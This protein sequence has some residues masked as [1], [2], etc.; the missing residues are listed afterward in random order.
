MPPAGPQLQQPEP[1]R[2]GPKP[3]PGKEIPHTRASARAHVKRHPDL[4]PGVD[5]DD[6]DDPQLRKAYLNS[7][8]QENLA[9]EQAREPASNVTPIRRGQPTSSG[10]SPA[11]SGGATH[12]V[13]STTDSVGSAVLGVIAYCVLWNAVTGGWAG[14]TRW[15][16]AKFTNGNGSLP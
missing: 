12:L 16:S 2:G 6:L 4:P 7:W 13:S 5:T 1:T 10:S 11:S 9:D 15:L 14:V 8:N 3:R